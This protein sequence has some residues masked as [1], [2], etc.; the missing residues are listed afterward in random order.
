VS[1]ASSIPAS[2]SLIGARVLC[3]VD[4][5]PEGLEA[6]RQAARLVELDGSLTLLAAYSAA[7]VATGYLGARAAARLEQEAQAALHDAVAAIGMQP[8]TLLINA[9]AQVALYREAERLDAT[10]VVV[11]THERSRGLGILRGSVT[12]AA[13]HRPAR[14]TLIARDPGTT[15]GRFPR[16]VAVGEDGSPASGYARAVAAAIAERF[17]TPFRRIVCV[18][19]DPDL[20]AVQDEPGA[21][22]I[23]Q[24]D[25]RRGLLAIGDEVDLLVVGA[26]GRSGLRALGSV[27][28]RVAHRARCSVLVA[29]TTAPCGVSPR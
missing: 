16:S 11:G 6:A 22:E 26:S 17:N 2:A 9:E 27:S 1:H 7:A 10:L 8:E 4:P 24:G 29:V 23:I 12:T 21:V 28:E 25:A 19:G 3:G 14:A 15:P 18:D 5:S 20:G 13:V